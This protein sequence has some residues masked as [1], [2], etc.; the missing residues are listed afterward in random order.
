MNK[1][2]INFENCY[3]IKKLDYEFDFN[4]CKT[5]AIY[6][7][8]GSMKTSF[9]KT[10]L[11]LSR[12]ENSKDSIHEN[13]E[14]I[15][16]IKDEMNNEIESESIFVINSYDEEFS[17]EKVS[18]L[19]ANNPL[20]KDYEKI[21]LKID[22]SKQ[23]LILSLKNDVNTKKKD[24]ESEIK[25][26][27]NKENFL[28]VI[29]E[30]KVTLN[31]EIDYDFS[32]VD[33]DVI[34]NDKSIKFIEDSNFKNQLEEYIKLYDALLEKS[35]F[36]KNGLNHYNANKISTELDKNN[37]FNAKHELN[38]LNTQDDSR[39]NIKSSKELNEIIKEEKE[40]ILNNSELQ[41]KF[42]SIDSKIKNTEL[43][44]LRE[45]LKEHRNYL[46]ELV[47]L[48]SFR[49]KIWISLFMQKK[50]MLDFLSNN[51]N[52]TEKELKDILKEIEKDQELWKKVIEEFNSRFSVPFKI[53][54]ENQKELILGNNPIPHFKYEFY[55]EM[56]A[57]ITSKHDLIDVLSRG[58]RRALYLLNIIFEVKARQKDKIE[59]LFIADD[60][61]DSFDYKNK[62]AIIEYLKEISEEPNFYQIILTHNFDFFRTIQGRLLSY[63]N[64][65]KC[66]I[67]SKNETEIILE[68][69]EKKG[70]LK[71]FEHWKNKVKENNELYL[72]PLIPFVRNLIEYV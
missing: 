13:L 64:I 49:K 20:R 22:S 50:D 4:K 15:R 54:I 37:F 58:E 52:E 7:P 72:I 63:K 62:Y 40:N 69:I 34:F 71:P 67:V 31:S 18:T 36:L 65:K 59:T 38:L 17:S 42:Q 47:D 5:Y 33:Y 70:L 48:D 16:N 51:I 11:D 41:K 53:K 60:I 25:N 14:T 28:E 26:T 21:M 39:L 56:G 27:F 2:K 10:F 44:E 3:G 35:R 57:K 29:K 30:L 24:I 61:A 43:R 23:S 1:L 12:K 9:A 6:A 8:N 55:D 66:L 68:N 46:T 45:Y 19:V 32:K